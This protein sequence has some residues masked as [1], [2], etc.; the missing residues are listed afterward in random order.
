MSKTLEQ[1]LSLLMD[2]EIT[3]FET[4][5][6]VDEIHANPNFKSVWQRM[7]KHKAAMHGELLDHN[8]D[9]SPKI[10]S[11][12]NNFSPKNSKKIKIWSN[13][14]FFSIT[15]MKVCCYLIGF[16]F[17]LSLPLLNLPSLTSNT[18][19]SNQNILPLNNEALLVDLGSNF[20][21][22]LKDFRI[23]SSSSMEANYVVPGDE[24]SLRLKVFFDNIP[25][26]EWLGT[27]NKGVTVHTRS[28]STP[29]ILNLSSETLPNQRL[30]KISNTFLENK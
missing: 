10:M 18:A 27:I 8:L 14:D 24:K 6:L 3:P 30:I 23:T 19:S 28:G 5:R 22:S 9:L 15:Y 12:I 7:N 21:G 17:I 4:K 26:N 11:Q 16:F 2:G 1:K 29:L 13:F 25:E 20:N